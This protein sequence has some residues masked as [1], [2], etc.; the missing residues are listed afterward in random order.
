M[1]ACPPRSSPVGLTVMTDDTATP[2]DGTSHDDT[3]EVDVATETPQ[4]RQARFEA[5][6]LPFLDQLY[7]AALRMTPT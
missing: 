5:D 7:S 2:D 1:L 3:I 4:Q 6:A